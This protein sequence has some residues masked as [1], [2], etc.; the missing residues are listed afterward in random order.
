M[1][2]KGQLFSK[3]PRAT[4]IRHLSRQGKSKWMD[5]Q[6]VAW[7]KSF[8]TPNRESG[9]LCLYVGYVASHTEESP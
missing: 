6:P 5:S 1:K 2:G 3:L 4:E 9:S 8:S 7:L